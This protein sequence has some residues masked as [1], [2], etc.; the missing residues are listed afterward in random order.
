MIPMHDERGSVNVR[1][2]RIAVIGEAFFKK[3]IGDLYG[4]VPAQ[5]IGNMIG[6]FS[7]FHGVGAE[8][9]AKHFSKIHHRTFQSQGP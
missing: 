4:C 7:L 8:L 2:G 5:H 3:G 1:G 6:A 9:Q